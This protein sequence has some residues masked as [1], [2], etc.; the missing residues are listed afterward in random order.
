ME[1]QCREINKE[2]AKLEST[3][4]EDW[5]LENQQEVKE[6][7]QIQESTIKDSIVK[8]PNQMFLK[9]QTNIKIIIQTCSVLHRIP[10]LF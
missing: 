8:G 6:D 1:R 5:T 7:F 9:I 10:N 3:S 4:M 2:R